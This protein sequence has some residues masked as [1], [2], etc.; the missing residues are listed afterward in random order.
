[1]VLCLEKD[2]EKASRVQLIRFLCEMNQYLPSYKGQNRCIL[3]HTI[4]EQ[5]GDVVV[6]DFYLQRSVNT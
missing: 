6:R 2:I 3:H 5:V 1:M 4:R